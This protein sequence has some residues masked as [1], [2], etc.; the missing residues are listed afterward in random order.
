M[1]RIE[2]K[3]FSMFS[4]AVYDRIPEDHMF[5]KL[6]QVIDF[7]FI[8][9]LLADR[10]CANFGRPAKEPELLMRLLFLKH[11]YDLSDVQVIAQASLNIAWVWFLGLNLEDELPHPSLLAK[12][13]T[14]RLGEFDLDDII[15]E[16][17][18][19]CVEN[20]LI[21]GDGVSVDATHIEANTI[22][23]VPERIMKH[24]ALKIFKA[25][26]KDLG[27]IPSEVDTNI[28][29]Y[30]QIEDHKQAKAVMKQYLLN[31]IQQADPFAKEH[32]RAAITEAL[33]I[34][35]D[36]RFIIQ[37]GLRSLIDKD[38]RVGRKSKHEPFFGYKAEFSMVADERIITAV[39][40]QSGEKTDGN[41]FAKLLE[42]TIQ[43]G[44][45][46]S[47]IYGD[48]AYC[49]PDIIRLI[50]SIGA[51]PI[52]P[53]S[54]SVYRINEDLF[55]Y[56]KDSDEW[57][58]RMG[59]RTVKKKRYSI[60]RDGKDYDYY[61]FT[62]GKELCMSC[63]YRKECLGKAKTKA[64][65]LKIGIYSNKLWELNQKQK[66]PEFKKAYKNRASIEWKNAELKR[67]HG[68]ARAI[69]YGLKAVTTQAKLV[70]IATNLKRIIALAGEKAPHFTLNIS[71]QNLFLAV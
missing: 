66:T 58:C 11:L 4:A 20:D 35:G 37:K 18:R 43:A 49:R 57:F 48:K 31:V 32:T 56:N 47:Q 25:L 36:E 44:V 64:R 15:T 23:K 50:E 46:P 61:L 7:S 14:Q 9:E 26:R 5:K 29:N 8:N 54:G 34:L 67:F 70:A 63:P 38:A 19:Q 51:E 52:I 12:F 45:N 69:G 21:K 65:E 59:N 22:R 6:E 60:K 1:L 2:L 16:I 68:L 10:Y 53:V 41:D 28:P 39:S 27:E 55:N 13:R 71:S 42:K 24:L 17:V 62:F 30:K 33:E 40:V 3:Q